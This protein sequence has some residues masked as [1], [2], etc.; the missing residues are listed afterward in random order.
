MLA[1]ARSVSP[2]ESNV[3]PSPAVEI[4]CFDAWC[5]QEI[6]ALRRFLLSRGVPVS[7]VDDLVQDSLLVVW[8]KRHAIKSGRERSFLYGIAMHTCVNHLRTRNRRQ[9][10]LEAQSEAVHPSAAPHPADI[11]ED[12]D[13]HDALRAAIDQLPTRTREVVVSVAIER[14]GVTETADRYGIS[15]K[16][17]SNLLCRAREKLRLLAEKEP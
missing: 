7:D 12:Q 3:A 13:R 8:E 14:R 1:A 15:A 17:V 9:R 6:P 16:T 5:R 11:L 4:S 2:P 10:L